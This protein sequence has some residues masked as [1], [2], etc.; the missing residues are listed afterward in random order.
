M[1]DKFFDPSSSTVIFSRIILVVF[2]NFLNSFILSILRQNYVELVFYPHPVR[3][4]CLLVSCGLSSSFENNQAGL[5]RL[6]FLTLQAYEVHE[7]PP[8]VYCKNSWVSWRECS[9]AHFL[10]YWSILNVSS[11][12]PISLICVMM[13]FDHENN[14]FGHRL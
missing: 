8:N 5:T 11:V 1:H 14:M 4:V 7:V 3:F 6:E 13:L 9:H 2:P 10:P 12:W